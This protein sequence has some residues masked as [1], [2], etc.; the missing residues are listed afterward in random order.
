MRRED[1]NVTEQHYVIIGNGPAGNEATR[2]LRENDPECRITVVAADRLPYIPRYNLFRVLDGVEDWRELLAHPPEYYEEM[3]ITLRR[4]TLV[5]SVD[6]G[7]KM[8]GLKHK[9]WLPYDKLLVASGGGGYLPEDLRDYRGLIHPFGSFEDAVRLKQDLPEAGQV[10]MLGGDM[11]GIYLG[12]KLIQLGYRVT[13]ITDVHLFWPHKL[14]ERDPTPYYH[15]LEKAGFD[16]VNGKKVVRIEQG[17]AGLS[18]RRVIC[19]DESVYTADVVLGCYGLM[20]K[21]DFMAHAGLDV[22]RG[23]LC[24]PELQ[25][26]DENIW[27]AGDVCQI[28]SPEENQYRVS[29]EWNSVKN[30]GRV[31]AIN[32]AGGHE[33]INTFSEGDVG[34]DEHGNLTS[35]FWDFD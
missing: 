21:L 16:L 8:I 2:H 33:V 24:T 31:A 20:P 12:Q 14:G 15:A 25:T 27:A 26:S 35:P 1:A 22:Q 5:T 32:M 19:E 7:R 30:M 28:W 18:P 34:L 6:T 4:N 17:E 13:L 23:L 10:V 3:R 11:M 9:E 29:Y